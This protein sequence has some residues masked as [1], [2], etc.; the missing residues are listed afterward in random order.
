MKTNYKLTLAAAVISV[1]MPT[2][3]SAHDYKKSIVLDARGNPVTTKDGSCVVHD[4][5]QTENNVC[6][7]QSL[8]IV[9][10]LSLPNVVYFG[11]DKSGLDSRGIQV[12]NAVADGV[13][14]LGTYNIQLVGHA[15]TVSSAGY[16]Q[17]LSAKRAA[18]VK[19]ALI[20]RGVN[21]SAISTEA[22]GESKNAVPTG[23][24]VPEAL[25]RR[26]EIIVTR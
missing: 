7:G 11:F 18:S 24:N 15:D 20:A 22:V 26:V 4:W 13:S 25:N 5:A 1:A 3:A 14:K 12:V 10:E 9:G 6:E 23:D 17:S 21:A 8:A 19:D 16:N 2:L